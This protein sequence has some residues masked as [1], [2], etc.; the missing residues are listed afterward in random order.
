MVDFRINAFV[1]HDTKLSYNI[2]ES[3]INATKYEIRLIKLEKISEIIIVCLNKK[4]QFSFAF[5]IDLYVFA[6]IAFLASTR[7]I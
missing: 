5:N 3:L 1:R 4:W 6:D 7:I 2:R